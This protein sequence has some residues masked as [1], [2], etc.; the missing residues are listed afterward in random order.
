MKQRTVVEFLVKLGEVSPTKTHQKLLS[1]YQ[2]ET[3]TGMTA[4]DVR[5][6]VIRFK[7]GETSIG[8]KP[9]SGRPVSASAPQAVELVD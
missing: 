8:D 3:M 7:N 2:E 5:R 4:T 1:V 9:R 6:W